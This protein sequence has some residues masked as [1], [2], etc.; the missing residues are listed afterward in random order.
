[1]T[2]DSI[3]FIDKHNGRGNLLGLVKQV[4]YPARADTYKHFHKITATDGK[5]RH[6]GLACDRLG[7]QGFTGSGRS[8]QQ[9]ALGNPGSEF[10]IRPRVLQE[11][12]HFLKFLLLFIRTGDIGKGYLVPGRILHPGTAFPE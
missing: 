1:M 6:T 5:E 8:D 10:G 7:Q 11:I 12:N 2:A 4:A 3:D 9:Y